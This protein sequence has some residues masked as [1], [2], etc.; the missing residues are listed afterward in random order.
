MSKYWKFVH[1]VVIF[2]AL[3]K[4]IGFAQGSAHPT[5]WVALT[6]LLCVTAPCEGAYAMSDLPDSSQ[7][8]FMQDAAAA[9]LAYMVIG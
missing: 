1:D 2:R 6:V 5:R 8:K 9:V 4:V 3:A 7:P